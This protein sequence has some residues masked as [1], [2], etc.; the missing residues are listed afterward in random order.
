[1]LPDSS[2]S[3]S[4]SPARWESRH[5]RKSVIA[6]TRGV[7]AAGAAAVTAIELMAGMSATTATASPADA[8]S[9]LAHAPITVRSDSYPTGNGELGREVPGVDCDRRDAQQPGS[10][11]Q[12]SGESVRHVPRIAAQLGISTAEDGDQTHAHE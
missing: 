4:T 9:L 7:A 11:P 6:D 1:M 5:P 3:R 8:R 2:M 10:P 12:R